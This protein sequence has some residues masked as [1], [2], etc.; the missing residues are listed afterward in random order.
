LLKKCKTWE[1]ARAVISLTIAG[2]NRSLVSEDDEPGVRKE[3]IDRFVPKATD[4][5]AIG[6]ATQIMDI[7][8]ER[9]RQLFP[10]L[11]RTI[12]DYDVRVVDGSLTLTVRSA[13][14]EMRK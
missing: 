7:V 13:L 9:R 1:Q 3:L 2:W 5:D 6:A 14:C 4:T 12:S 8:A 10:G 11:R